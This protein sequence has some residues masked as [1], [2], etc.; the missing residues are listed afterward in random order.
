MPLGGSPLDFSELLVSL[1]RGMAGQ[2][3]RLD[4]E[5]RR[6]LDDFLRMLGGEVRGSVEERLLLQVVPE[7]LS[8]KEV[9]IETT[10]RFAVSSERRM[11]LGVELL[12]LGFS[13]RYAYSG[14]VENSLR[15]NI[16]RLEQPPEKKKN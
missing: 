14:H 10:F 15:V 2:Q 3:A 12:N 7:R 6:R 11:S 5:Y 8:L 9:E 16:R 13:R 4:E 1:T